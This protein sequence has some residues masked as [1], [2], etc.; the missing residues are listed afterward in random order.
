MK[1][2]S[3]PLSLLNP[4]LDALDDDFLR[5]TLPVPDLKGSLSKVTI[6]AFKVDSIDGNKRG[7]GAASLTSFQ[8]RLKLEG[9]PTQRGTW[10]H[11]NALP[12]C[13]EMIAS[14]RAAVLSKNPSA[15]DPPPPKS[16][17]VT[18]PSRSTNIGLVLFC[19]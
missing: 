8:Y 13:R 11:G 3:V 14:Y 10:R 2:C 19:H 17:P 16:R 15:F 5:T 4:D 18:R 7:V 12:Q 1:K 6:G 9:Y